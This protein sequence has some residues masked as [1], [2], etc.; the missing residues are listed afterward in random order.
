MKQIYIS[1]AFL[2]F[3]FFTSCFDLGVKDLKLIKVSEIGSAKIS[4]T[5]IV[6]LLH[7]EMGI[8]V[9]IEYS[10]SEDTAI[11]LLTE[12]KGNLAIVPNNTDVSYSDDNLRTIMPLLPRILVVLQNNIDK[13]YPTLKELLENNKVVFEEMSR[14][15]SIFFNKLFL[16]YDV[17]ISKSNPHFAHAIDLNLWQD[18]SFVF[19]GLTHFHNPLMKKLL[20]KGARFYSLDKVSELGK[21]SSVEGFNMIFPKLTP[22]ILPKSFYKGKPENPILTIA[23]PDILIT[24]KDMDNYTVYNIIRIISENKLLLVENDNIYSLLNTKY[25]NQQWLYPI[26]QGAQNY[27][28][29]D[30]P[31]VWSTYANVLW[32]F[33]SMIA[34]F[35]GGLTSIKQRVRQKKKLRIETFYASLLDLRKRAYRNQDTSTREQLLKELRSIRARAFDSLRNNKLSPNESFSIFLE[36][37]SEVMEE[38]EGLGK[39]NIKKKEEK[40]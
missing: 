29:K 26:H 10:L 6:K 21:G 36:L 30:K 27:L 13:N 35:L 15:D 23:I 39:N 24:T 19:I 11:K 1:L 20:D 4:D 32:P 22:F 12:R 14:L 28:D 34:I 5:S 16:A 9:T 40:S 3:I 38:I 2:F 17:D 33:V 8:D 18:S 37:Y 31:S 7:K 25:K